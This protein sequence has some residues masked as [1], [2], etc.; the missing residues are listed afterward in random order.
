M[1]DSGAGVLIVSSDLAELAGLADRILVFFRGAVVAD[2]AARDADQDR[3]LTL[4]ATGRDEKVLDLED[5][6]AARV[7]AA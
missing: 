2:V 6:E 1:A 4:L 3:L 5:G 7:F